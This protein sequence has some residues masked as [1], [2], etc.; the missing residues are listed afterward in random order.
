VARSI[1]VEKSNRFVWRRLR[2]EAPHLTTSA[3]RRLCGKIL[4]QAAGAPKKPVM[5][6][7]E[8]EVLFAVALRRMR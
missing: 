3:G 2:T 7:E 6:T 8:A 5:T 4:E 1:K